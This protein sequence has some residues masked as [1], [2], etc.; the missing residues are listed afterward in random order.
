MT[1]I[2]S[3]NIKQ[4]MDAQKLWKKVL[5]EMKLNLSP[6]NYNMWISQTKAKR[7]TSDVLEIVCSTT[8][9]KNKIQKQFH[10]LVQS[11]VNKLGKGKYKLTF[12]IGDVS[13]GNNLKEDDI[14]PLFE[15]TSKPE[16]NIQGTG[17]NPNFIFKNYVMGSNN[18]LAYA[19]ATAIIENPGKLYNPFFLYSGVGLGKTHLI[20]AIGNKILEEKSNLKVIYTTGESFTNEI[21]EA[22]QSGQRSRGNYSTNKFRDKY[23]KT[24]V[25]LIDDIQFIAGKERTQEEFFHTFNTLHMAQKQIVI[26]SDRPPKDFKNIEERITSRFGSGIIADIQPPDLDTRVAILRNKRDQTNA[27]ISNEIIDFIAQ[28]ITTN[29][30]ELEGAFIQVLSHA[31][32]MGLQITAETATQALGQSIKEEKKKPINL[33]Q[34]IKTVANYYSIKTVDIKGK[35]RTK[36]I[37]IPRQIAMFLIYDLT[38]TPFMSI[39]EI[40]GGRDHT[41]VMHGVRKVEQKLVQ[42]AKIK[43]DLTNIRHILNN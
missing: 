38:E 19:I 31:K 16:K 10:S 3:K 30:R 13:K 23:R 43:Q 7:L 14:G 37:V 20:H 35:R 4:E 40:L 8:Y 15:Q 32:A 33:N 12:E 41:T 39:G 26:T 28:K 27:D 36:D 2:P 6:L 25:L 24:D 5:D 9:V 42:N 29:V 21:I 17:L 22:I 1:L 11:S 18:Q 34:I